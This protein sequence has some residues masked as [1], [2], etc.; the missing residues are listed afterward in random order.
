MEISLNSGDNISYLEVD[1]G[2]GSRTDVDRNTKKVCFKEGNGEEITDMLVES[3]PSPKLSWKDKLLEDSS[4]TSVKLALDISGAG[5]DEDLEFLEGNIHRS[6]V[7]GIP[8]IN[9]SERI[10]QILFKEME[11]TVVLKLH[12]R[13]IGNG[14]L[15]NRISSLWSPSKP[16]HLMDIENG[17]F[18]AKFQSTDDYA[19]VLS[20]GPWLIYG[21]ILTVQPWTKEFNLRYS[22]QVS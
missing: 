1:N 8:G 11:L 13:N 15:S 6:I 10:Q 14:A 19:K 4:R 18:L 9:F 5:A 12:G 17:Y 20:Q 22:Y 7:N 16:F 21:Q 2:D 3:G